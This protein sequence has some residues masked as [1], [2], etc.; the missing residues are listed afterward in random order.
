VSATAPVAKAVAVTPVRRVVVEAPAV[1]VAKPAVKA[2]VAKP[3]VVA[4]AGEVL[5]SST[6]GNLV[7]Q[8]EPQL[9]MCYTEDGL[10]ANPALSGSIVVR[11]AIRNTGDVSAVE[12]PQHSW[13]ATEGAAAVEAC[14]RGRVKGWAFPPAGS[15][16]SHDF[17]VLFT[18]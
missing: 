12:I 2:A 7:R 13:S 4:G 16:S 15:A 1:A 3:A 14:V 8:W 11:V 18:Q 6:V 10:K 17:K 5:E 9:Q